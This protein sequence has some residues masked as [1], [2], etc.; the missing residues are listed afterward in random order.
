MNDIQSLTNRIEELENFIFQRR[1]QQVSY[2]IDETSI[3]ILGDKL[4]TAVVS[5]KSSSSENQAVS[6]G[7]AASYN[8]LKAPDGFLQ[9]TIN[10][11]TYYI[12]IFT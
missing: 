1:T 6:E 8:V 10:S 12:P 2:P 5:S 7:G 3:K 9:I 11:S 4:G